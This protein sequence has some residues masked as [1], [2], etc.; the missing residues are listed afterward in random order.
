MPQSKHNIPLHWIKGRFNV[1]FL[2]IFAEIK[3]FW[4]CPP[5]Y[6]IQKLKIKPLVAKVMTQMISS[7]NSKSKSKIHCNV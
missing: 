5:R 1:F 4:Q 2:E 6:N 7:L 3:A